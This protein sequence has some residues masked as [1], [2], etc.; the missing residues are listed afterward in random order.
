MKARSARNRKQGFTLIELLVVIAIIAILISLLLPAVQQA[1]EAARRTQCRNNLKQLGLAA[2]N[3]H[4][5]HLCLPPA[6]I[7]NATVDPSQAWHSFH[8]Y[9][10]P[11][12]DQGNLYD[13][14]RIDLT[15]FS[16]LPAPVSP[17]DIR[18][19]ET[20][21]PVFRCPSAPGNGL[22]DYTEDVVGPGVLPANTVVGATTDYA[23]CD[24]IGSDFADLIGP[25]EPDGE[26]GLVRFNR[27]MKFRNCTDGT[28]NT[29]LLWEDAG[30]P[31]VWQL[32]QNT[33]GVNSS[34][35]WFDM[36][37]EFY[38]HGSSLDGS[39][40]R[41]AINC[42]NEDEVYSF[43]TGGAQLALADGSVHFISENADFAV[44]AAYVSC[45]GGEIP[46]NLFGG[47]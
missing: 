6:G 36:Q 43:H 24:G 47:F 35:G 28:S 42:T 10:L 19:G 26:T 45:A 7:H 11:Y 16:N 41:C 4:D 44:I 3:Y 5:V 33:G 27:A 38:I 46:G 20:Q 13:S 18:A 30:R 17:L 9:V 37:T 39:G 22:R 2:H 32:G 12:I 14:M 31:D 29:A 23:V 25:D 21:I 15:I 8:T 40:G 34:G 1:R